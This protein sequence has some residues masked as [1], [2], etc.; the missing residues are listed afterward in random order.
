VKTDD[1]DATIASLNKMLEKAETTKDKLAITDR[2]LK[3]YGMR[4]KHTD[5]G[6]GTKFADL[7]QLTE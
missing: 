3:C 7:V 2:L 5:K 6:T 1:L 4:Y